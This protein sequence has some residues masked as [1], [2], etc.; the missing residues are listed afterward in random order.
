MNEARRLKELERESAELKKMLAV[1]A[2]EPLAGSRMLATC[3]VP[4]PAVGPFGL[5]LSGAAIGLRASGLDFVVEQTLPHP[6]PA[7][8]LRH[9]PNIT[10]I[11]QF[12][13]SDWAKA[14]SK[15]AC[16]A[17]L[18]FP[19]EADS[20]R[21]IQLPRQVARWSPNGMPLSCLDRARGDR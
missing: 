20:I 17:A 9:P 15:P 10:A 19:P 12:P 2:G 3:S 6:F 8:F 4:S 13:P 1:T 21:R 16:Q 7:S 14:K 11:R 18:A 5:W